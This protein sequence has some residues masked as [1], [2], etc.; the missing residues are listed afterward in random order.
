MPPTSASGLASPL[1]V[2]HQVGLSTWE[3]EQ[4]RWTETCG[5]LAGEV[6]GNHKAP[7]TLNPFNLTLDS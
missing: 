6:P 1:V 7:T 2:C 3:V 5:T 4:P